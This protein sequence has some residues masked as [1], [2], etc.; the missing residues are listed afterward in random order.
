MGKTSIHGTGERFQRIA[1]VL[2]DGNK[3]ELAR[4]LGMKP[5]SFAKYTKGSRRPGSGVLERLSR[6]G[7]NIN[8][9]LSGEGQM[10]KDDYV[11][12]SSNSST[13]RVNPTQMDKG[14]ST[15]VESANSET[16]FFRIP[17]LRIRKDENDIYRLDE[18]EGIA[19]LSKA[20]V[21]QQYGTDVRRLREF[22]LSGNA[23]TETIRPGDRLL[24]EMF[25]SESLIDG[26]IYLVKGAT[27]V[28]VRRVNLRGDAIALTADNSSTPDLD[29]DLETWE[30]AYRPFARILEVIRSL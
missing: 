10:M 22:R 3:S 5:S 23:M 27:G 26:E 29:V 15:T 4:S 20:F 18:S 19:C 7:V 2:F 9:F 30:E 28:L 17:I 14:N 8:W 13:T 24:V 6:L 1:E 25:D 12:S 16:E 21:H 11:P